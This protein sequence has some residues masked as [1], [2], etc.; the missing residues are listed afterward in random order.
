MLGRRVVRHTGSPDDPS[1]RRYLQEPTSDSRRIH[2][3]E[4]LDRLA[5]HTYRAPE[6][7]IKQRAA[8]LLRDGL[9]LTHDGVRG[10]VHDNVEPA[11]L[12]L[13]RGEGVDDVLRDA[14]IDRENE[15]TVGGV[16]GDEVIEC[17]GSTGG[18]DELLA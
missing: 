1:N 9:E 14:D 17:G 18:R 12:V 16:L 8:V 4:E 7:C 3:A 10:V 15:Q 5:R 13:C 11:E 6:V 2:L